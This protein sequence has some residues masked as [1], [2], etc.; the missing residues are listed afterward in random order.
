MVELTPEQEAKI[1][2]GKALDKI[3]IAFK[4]SKYF[5]MFSGLAERST[6]GYNCVFALKS[7]GYFFEHN[8]DK[9]ILAAIKEYNQILE[10]IKIYLPK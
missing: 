9:E 1:K 10:K 4:K 3:Y 8:E 2:L 7:L 6:E 5:E